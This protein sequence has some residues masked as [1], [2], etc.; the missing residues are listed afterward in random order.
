MS[1][2]ETAGSRRGAL[3]GLAAAALF[4]MS[5]PLAKL[6]LDEMR[7]QVLAGLLY[8]GAGIAFSVVGAARRRTSEAKL[9]RKDVFPLL[10]LIA[11]G[12][13][14]GPLLLLI[15]LERTSGMA[16]ALA[17]NLEAPFTMLLAVVLFREHFGRY[18]AGATAL[19]LLGAAVLK[20]R[21]GEL[22]VDGLGLVF[23]ALACAAWALDNNL[24]QRLTLK[25]PIAIVR[26][27]TLV[28]GAFN[29]GLGLILG[30]QLPRASV[31]VATL[32]LGALSYGLSV[33]LDAYALRLLGAAR[34]AAFFATAPFLGAL[35][36]LLFLGERLAWADGAAMA[37]MVGGVVLLLRERHAHRH[38]HEP[39]EHDH[40]HV[41]D[42][43]HQ[44]E[45][46]P[47]VVVT[48]RHAH[49]HRH[50]PLVHEHPH[51]SDLHHR[52][53]H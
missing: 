26:L 30:G 38:E 28:A 19:I 27:K 37:A 29:L 16:A 8:L 40:A 42:E 17:L 49:A 24:T 34:E 13:V 32:F 11:S 52:H 3:L 14:V 31:L 48:E 12:G 22:G 35:G 39:L 15:G 47:G 2:A 33:L 51:G 46:A 53:R 41:H 45:H 6:L 25:D 36:S 9:T 4:G 18:A 10:G 23:I 21:P 43:H 5:T 50:A 7:P 20:V 1:G 44:H